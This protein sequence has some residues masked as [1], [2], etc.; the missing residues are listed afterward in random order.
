MHRKSY[1]KI[2]KMMDKKSETFAVSAS[3]NV[4]P[5]TKIY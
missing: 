4:E 2:G 3:I 1:G 5:S